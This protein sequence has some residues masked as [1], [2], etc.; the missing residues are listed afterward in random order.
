MPVVRHV[1]RRFLRLKIA[2]REIRKKK[3]KV[4]KAQERLLKRVSLGLSGIY[5]R[6]CPLP[7]QPGSTFL[8]RPDIE[9]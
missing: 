2:L 5:R 6:R 3:E 7:L 1:S 9:F 8:S 4:A